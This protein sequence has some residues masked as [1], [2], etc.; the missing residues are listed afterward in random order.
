MMWFIGGLLLG[1]MFG[2]FVAALLAAAARADHAVKMHEIR[3]A[4]M[5]SSTKLQK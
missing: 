1:S 2:I 4:H 5:A 3:K